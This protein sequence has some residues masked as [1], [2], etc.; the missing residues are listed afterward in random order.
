MDKPLARRSDQ[1][2]AAKK[3]GLEVL[4]GAVRCA[5]LR[6]QIKSVEISPASML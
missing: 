1:V 5:A 4:S 2:Q 3:A 6:Y